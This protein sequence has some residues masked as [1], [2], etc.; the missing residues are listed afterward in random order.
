MI[1]LLTAYRCPDHGLR[2]EALGSGDEG[3]LCSFFVTNAQ[4]R[5]P[6]EPVLMV[7]VGDPGADPGLDYVASRGWLRPGQIEEA[8]Q[9]GAATVRTYEARV[10]ALQ[11][12]LVEALNGNPQSE[13]GPHSGP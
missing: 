7:E 13:G 3:R 10:K 12:Q 6:V 1:E 11:D 8:R 4:C 5:K 9:A 2:F